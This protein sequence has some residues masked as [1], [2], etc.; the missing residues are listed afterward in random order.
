MT[1]LK[2]PKKEFKWSSKI[3][4]AVGLLVTD[5][6]LSGDGRH[7][8][9]R[10][11][12]VSQLRTFKKCLKLSNRIARSKND[13]WGKNPSYRV[14][15]GNVQF[16]R[17]LI[18]IGLFPNKTYT[19]GKIKLPSKYFRDFLRG[20]LDGDGTIT[21]YK[22]Y[23]NTFKN[24]KYIYTRLWVRFMSASKTHIEWIRENIF[25]LIHIKGHTAQA[26]IYRSYQTA[27]MWHLKFGKKESTKLLSW[28]YYDKNVPCL[29]RKRDIAKKILKL[30]SKE[31]RRK[32]TRIRDK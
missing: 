21:T 30:I 12:E 11:S 20:H 19:I 10:S 31:K 1:R 26:K 5:G 27:R 16:Y 23:Y 17:W 25:K 6:N 18:K 24:P 3:A 28:I 29:K 32:Y 13:G 7:M 22:D 14:Q 2:L 9:M 4:Y 15:F 8:T